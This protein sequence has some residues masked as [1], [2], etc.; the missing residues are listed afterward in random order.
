MGLFAYYSSWIPN[1]SDKIHSINHNT[2]FPLPEK[3]KNDFENL[4]VEIER[5]AIV[6]IDHLSPLVV[7]TDASDIA[8]AATL[9]QNGRPVAFFSR[10]LNASEK[11]LSSVEK[12][13]YAII[14]SLRK[15]R[16]FLI[17]KHF[18][19]ITDQKSVAF[20][21][22]MSL[23]TKIKNDKIQRWRMELSC[24]SFE[25]VYRPGEENAA[26]DTL[27]RAFCSAS[28]SVKSLQEIHD[29]LCHPGITRLL[30][31]VKA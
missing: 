15:W 6:T 11:K 30:H 28:S 7:E 25:C 3:V 17:G 13:A 20:M 2:D 4:K 23:K 18:K 19:L 9:N 31:F 21:Y 8:I 5:A 12:E 29:S 24:F 1:F 26:A 10:S 27:S 14:E 22:D 16:H